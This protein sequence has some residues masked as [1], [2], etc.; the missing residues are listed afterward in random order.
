MRA[1]SLH[2]RCGHDRNER[3]RTAVF[4]EGASVGMKTSKKS[5]KP[6][7]GKDKK[8]S[9]AMANLNTRQRTYV[10]GLADGKTKKDAALDAGYSESSAKCA[11]A[12]IERPN[13]RL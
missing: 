11:T 7:T 13:V 3:R 2:S 10:K 5:M 9:D 4:G 1:T 12:I 6:A 8:L